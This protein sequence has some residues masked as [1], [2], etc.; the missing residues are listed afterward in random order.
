[1]TDFDPERVFAALAEHAVD[2]VTVGGM[3]LAA[4][5]VVRATV[6]VDIIPSPAPDN[7]NR[8]RAALAGLRATPHG[9]PQTDIDVALLAR[10]ANMRFETDAGQLDVLLAEPY[11]RGFSELAARAERFSVGA[12]VVVVVSRNDLILL[13]A[14]TGRDRDLLDIGDLLAAD[15]D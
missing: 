4:H 8:L 11:R 1:M 10:D 12:T 14:A 15:S 3:A 5:G 2:Y 9:E 7:L 6:D 13:K